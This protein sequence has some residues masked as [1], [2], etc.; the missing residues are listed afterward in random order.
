MN[1]IAYLHHAALPL[2]F[3]FLLILLVSSASDS[4]LNSLLEFKKG[5]LKDQHNSVI[6]KWDLA[7]VSNSDVN[8]CPSS[9]TGVSCDENGNVSAIVLD[10]LGLGGELKFQTLIGLKSLKNLSLSGNDFTG[11]LVPALGT[12][13][14][15][16]HLDLSSN[17]F[18]GPIPERINDLYNLNYL[19]FSANDFN[20][21]FPVGRL[22][23]NQLKVLD[24]HSNR[25]Y[26]NI[27]L[28]VSQLRN[29][30]YVDLSHNEFYGGLSVGSENI[31]S[32][33]NTLRIFN[34]SYNRLNGGFFDVDSLML[35]RNLVVL[36]MGHNQIIGE[37]PSFGSLPNLRTVRLD[38]N[39]LSGSVPGELLNRSLQL[40]E[41][42]LS[43][44]AFTGS[45]LRVDSSTLK[46]LDLS[47]NALSGDISVLQTWEANFE[48][49]DLSSNKF[50]GSFPNSTS[51][52]GLKVLNV[53]NNLL[54]G[55]LPFTLGNY[56]SMSAVDF[57]LNDLSGTIPASLFT[58][59]TLISLNLSGNRFTGPIP[60]QDSS[61]SE[62]LVKPSD[63][64][65]EYLDL[66][67]NSLIGGLPPE[68]DKL[69]S[70]KL[71]NLA[72]NELSG[73]L[74][75]QLNRLS[76]LEYLDLSNNKF[77]GEIPDMLPNLH[78]FNV[79]YNYLSGSVPENLRNFPVSSFRPGN[80]KLS[81][82]KDIG[83]EN[84]IPDSLPEQGKR[85]TSKANIRIAIILASV[86]TVVM[87][88]FLLLAYHRAQRKEFHGRSIFS[89]Q[90]TERNNKMERFRPSIFKFQLNN[91]P[92]PTSSSFSNDHL[93]TATS[94]TL[95]GQAEFSSEISEHVLPGGAATSSSMIIPNLL[96]DHPVTSA[97]NSS[98][99]SPLSSSHQF[100]EGRELPVTLDVYSPDR[101]AGELFFLDNSLLFTAE[102]LS[103][104][105]AEVLGRSSH[106][107]L[108]KATLDSGHML[109]V[110]WLRVGLV[111][112]KKE[113]AKEVKRIGSMRHKS[114]VPLRAYYW[115]PREQERL[116][117]A[118][119]ILGDSLALHLY[120]TTPRSYSR[121]TFS[122]RLKIA[123]EVA[124]CL[125]YLH[126]SG[127]PHGNLKP[128]NIILAGHDSDARL[129]DYGLH[130]LMT[131][132]GIAEQI[133]NLG[134]LGYCAPELACAA[135]PGPS[136]K[137]DIYSFGVIL[138]E[139][140]TKRSAGDIIS[141]QSGAVD[142]TD[143]VRLCDQEG[144]RMD[145][146]DRDIVV[147]EEPSKAMDELLAISLKCILPVNE[148][149]NI[150]QVFDDLCAISV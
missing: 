75:D 126:D 119:F 30:E 32:L 132:A 9:W 38:N 71:L 109:A 50:T 68:I 142:L 48:V 58:S 139:L 73:S 33:A 98:P 149:P 97:K 79:S 118:D 117:L 114:I 106:G 53:R 124:R 122:Q 42:D 76:N 140:L 131:P 87:I 103:R 78:V 80:D 13:S 138:M 90:G 54:V 107:T 56:P 146:I 99:G 112:H 41:L 60:L 23:L 134:A 89:G 18:Y 34:L 55:P 143:W 19:N 1:I 100:V 62:L 4:E 104:A 28:L 31:S 40:E 116:L 64:P 120:E 39:L 108:Y 123:V 65:M 61:V 10:R 150:R 57:S 44:N 5:I 82:P 84:S 135:K 15:L 14:S 20:G 91:Q 11:R 125:L 6:G 47:S 111:K 51:F 81:L 128:T 95:S 133:L 115:G 92:P 102:E 129:T 93:L 69:A 8:G 3:I 113:F 66:S 148:R 70:L 16:Q 52:E 147:G 7:F 121:L 43:G 37:L 72:K 45:I 74:P 17:R 26:G 96:D 86:G 21:G 110:K 24:L 63:L 49:L 2:N 46:F 145:C 83:S 67:N 25:L 130:R 22:N 105:P 136:F 88:V 77:T 59:I 127:L 94:R 29:V 36:D 101:L 141:G 35:F 85:G 12:L 137:A 27:G 144:R